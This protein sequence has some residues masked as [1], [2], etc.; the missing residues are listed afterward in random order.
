MPH[1]RDGRGRRN[2]REEEDVVD[3][4][5]DNPSTSTREISQ[6]AVRRTLQE[7]QRDPFHV[8]LVH[9][10]QPGANISVSI[11][12]MGATQDCGHPA[13]SVSCVVD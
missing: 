1:G 6:S 7:K 4:I 13:I 2:V 9:G 3:I 8:R 12:P 11:S 5:H 10:L